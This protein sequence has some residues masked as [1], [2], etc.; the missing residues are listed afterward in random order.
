L[1]LTYE[2]T[3]RFDEEERKAIFDPLIEFNRQR[4]GEPNYVPL[5]VL[6]HEKQQRLVG[7]LWGHTAYNWFVIELLFLPEK[8][9]G[10]GTAT[11][12]LHDAEKEAIRRGCKNAW[13]D[14]HEFQARGFYESRGYTLF[15][16]LQDYPE[17]H[18]RYFMQKAL[19][20]S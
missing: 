20:A 7:G 2:L 3:S 13:M 11:A 14:T 19:S 1:E 8:L 12:I 16:E 6:V 18:A 5:N 9:R 4:A 17:G 15:G 10:Q